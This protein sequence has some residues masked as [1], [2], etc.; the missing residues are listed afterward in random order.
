MYRLQNEDTFIVPDDVRYGRRNGMPILIP[1]PKLHEL[2]KLFGKSLSK[3]CTD[4]PVTLM[5][6][7]HGAG[8]ISQ[9]IVREFSEASPHAERV[10]VAQSYG[11]GQESTPVKIHA[12]WIVPERDIEDRHVVLIDDIFDSG[13]TMAA[14]IEYVERFDPAS[15]ETFFMLKKR[16]SNQ[17][18]LRPK[19]VMAEIPDVWVVGAGL[20]DGGKYRHLPYIAEKPRIV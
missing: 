16:R 9:R 11:D 17:K 1:R 13:D 10:L 5:P 18:R 7:M 4:R 2:S 20:D 14:A 15:V 3:W 6:L 8:W 12:Q 19:W